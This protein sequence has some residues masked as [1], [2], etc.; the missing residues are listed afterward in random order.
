MIISHKYKFI[1]IKT[2]KTAGTSIEYNLSKYLG[3]DD[4]ITPSFEAKHLSQNYHLDT[5]ISN[6]LKFLNLNNFSIFFKKKLHDHIHAKK[7]KNI[8]NKNVYE[9]YFKFCVEREPVDK[10]ISYYFMRKN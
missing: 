6:F 4:V 8:I 9:N 2:R 1:F 3:K 7:L 10:C 5:K